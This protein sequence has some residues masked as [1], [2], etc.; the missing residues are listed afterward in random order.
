MTDI[1]DIIENIISS[2][3]KITLESSHHIN[4]PK[5]THHIDIPIIVHHIDIS[6][7]VYH[8]KSFNIKYCG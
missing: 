6:I 2:F 1:S 8:I 3:S 4:T 7:I 5:L